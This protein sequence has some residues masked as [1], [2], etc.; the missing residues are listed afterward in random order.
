MNDETARTIVREKIDQAIGFM[1]EEEIDLWLIYASDGSDP[2]LPLIPGLATVGTGAFLLSADGTLTAVCSSIDAQDIR[3][4]GLFEEVLEYGAHVG[5]G[6]LLPKAVSAVDHRRVALNYSKDSHLCD[7]L[8]EGRY[9]ALMKMLNAGEDTTVDEYRSS[10]RFLTRVRSIKSPREIEVIRRA[11]DITIEIYDEAIRQMRVGMTER[12][13]GSLFVEAMRRRGVVNGIDRRLSMPIVM[14]ERFAHR[15]PGD[16]VIEPGDLVIIDFSVDVEGYVSDIARTVYF[17]RPGEDTPPPDVTDAFSAVYG[18]IECAR[19]ALK[20]GVQGYQVDA[21]ARS[22]LLDHGYPEITHATGH[23]IGRAVH[24]GGVLLGPRWPRYGSA[25]FGLIEEGMVFTIEP[26]IIEE[27]KPSFIV[28]DNWIV[29][30]GGVEPLSRRQ[31]H[32]IVVG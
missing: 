28:E 23:Q 29:R 31:D 17:L 13:I 19:S 4:S 30:D 12:E 5:I 7:G 1:R 2:V 15:G 24:D 3:E 9:R 21:A 22:Y 32:L 10:E 6:D 18:A 11:V 27:G 20:P 8:T 25:P 16:A 14:K 26:T